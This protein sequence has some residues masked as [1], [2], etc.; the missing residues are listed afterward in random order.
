ME[1]SLQLF[2]SISNNRWFVKTS[3]ILF[4]NKKD[5]FEDK[6][7]KKPLS[8]CFPEFE[9]SKSCEEAKEFIKK[10][11][12]ELAP[13]GKTIYTHFT[14]ATD[15]SNIEFVFLSVSDIILR[16]IFEQCHTA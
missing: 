10:K 8:V 7:K 2:E 13:K 4:L 5:L 1:D 14:C 9:D 11:F 12:V 6:I 16:N 15:I 3:I